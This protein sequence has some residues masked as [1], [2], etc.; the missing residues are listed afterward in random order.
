MPE[1]LAVAGRQEKGRNQT[2]CIY[3]PHDILLKGL[4][5][6]KAVKDFYSKRFKIW[7]KEITKETRQWKYSPCSWIGKIDI[8]E[9]IVRYQNQVVELIQY[10]S[11][12]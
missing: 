3:R 2:I 11:N 6:T 4:Y 12:F 8:M 1:G 7:G 5:L 10:L 9:V